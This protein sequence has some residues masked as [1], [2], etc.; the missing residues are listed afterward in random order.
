[1][2]TKSIIIGVLLIIIF[3]LGVNLA[4]RDR[5]AAQTPAVSFEECVRQGNP[6]MESSPRQC[7]DLSGTV[8]TE[9]TLVAEPVN[10][11]RDPRLTVASARDIALG[12][13]VCV[14]EGRVGEFIEFEVGTGMWRFSIEDS[15]RKSCS[16]ECVVFDGTGGVEVRCDGSNTP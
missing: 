16:P 6:V 1:M 4:V 13:S 5:K 14:S 7:R 10:D 11:L 2:Q 8:H 9:A 15:A 3:A 12:S